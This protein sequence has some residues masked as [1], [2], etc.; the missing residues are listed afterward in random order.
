MGHLDRRS[1]LV[2]SVLRAVRLLECFRP[3]EP[4]LSLAEVVRRGGY[5]KSTTYRLLSTLQVAGWLER[6]A[7]QLLP[8]DTTRVSDRLGPCRYT[9]PHSSRATPADTAFHRV[10]PDRLS[11]CPRRNPRRLPRTDQCRGP[12]P[13]PRAKDRWLPAAARRRCPTRAARFR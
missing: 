1:P 7:V 13:C 4:E 3:S 8:S 6:T 10:G 12:D 9:Q 11:H 2:E 5:S